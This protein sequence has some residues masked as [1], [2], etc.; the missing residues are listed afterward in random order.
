MTTVTL[1]DEIGLEPPAL[2]G[3]AL[4][5]A[6]LGYVRAALEDGHVERALAFLQYA[7]LVAYEAH[8][9][10]SR[11]LNLDMPQ[12]GWNPAVAAAARN[13][14][15]FF[16]DNRRSMGRLAAEVAQFDMATR[17]A[18]MSGPMRRLARALGIRN[19]DLAVL[20]VRSVPVATNITI[21]F[22][23]GAQVPGPGNIREA[24]QVVHDLALGVGQMVAEI[25][26]ADTPHR[27]PGGGLESDWSWGDGV[28]SDCYAE[29]FA[30]DI[31]RTYVPLMLMLQGAAA[32]AAFAARTDC[33]E[34]CQVAA[35]KHR[36]VVAHHLARSMQVLI[37]A[38]VLDP[39]ALS[40]VTAMLTT[41][42]VV[43]VLGLRALR[44]G[45]VHLGVSDVPA[46]AFDS[47][48]PLPAVVSH[49]SSGR[50]YA[51]IDETVR[52]ALA[53]MN[54]GLSGWLLTPTPGGVGFDGL[55]RP[56]N[57]SHGGR[58][59]PPAASIP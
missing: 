51:V 1:P 21:A 39:P 6:D 29:A 46:A 45:L 38:R 18:F 7:V 9:F 49:Y 37:D 20:M 50:S 4:A 26:A 43:D 3:L 11:Q 13:G 57:D 8:A 44:N 35:F 25:G 2:L 10:G 30:G 47:P 59:T 56:P 32:T 14:A 28:S 48:A 17:Q 24:G 33:C 22:N 23:T 5:R 52:Q 58:P 55:L 36:L 12:L 31:P 19:P 42:A 41:S 40:R 27:P 53:H 15:K 34:S 54:K 16:D